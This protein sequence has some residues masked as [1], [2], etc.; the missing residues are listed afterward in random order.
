MKN[1]RFSLLTFLI[2][3][4]SVIFGQNFPYKSQGLTDRQAAEHLLSRFTFGIAP[5]DIDFAVIMGLEKWFDTQ[6]NGKIS[7][8]ELTEKLKTFPAISMNTETIINNYLLGAQLRKK[9]I[10]E[11]FLLKED[12]ES[13]KAKQ[14]EAYKKLKEKYGVQSSKELERQTVNQKVIRAIYAKNQMHEVLTDFWFNHF[15]VF[16]GKNQSAQYV[17][18]YERDVIR[19][20]VNKN[21]NE[22]LLATAKSPAMLTYLDNFLSSDEQVGE[23][24]R[25][26]QNN[27]K[28]PK[29]LNENYAREI[30]ELHTLGV[31]GG[32][33]QTD[34][35]N[36]AKILTGWTLY[37][38]RKNGEKNQIA[39]MLD[40]IGEDRLAN[41]GFVRDGDFLF[42]ANRHV[43]GPKSV[44][45]KTYNQGGYEEG[46][47]LINDLAMHPS[48]A[49]F[50]SQKIAVRF[51]SDKPNP[52]LIDK[53]ARTF[54]ETKGNISKVIRT[55]VETPEF[56]N[57][58]ARRQKT[59]S[60][61]EYAVSAVR[62]LN[63]DVMF[64]AA[65]ANQIAKM[66]QKLYY[67]QAPT[68]FPD[69]GQYWINTGSLLNRMNFGLDIAAGKIAGVRIDAN[70]VFGNK[71]PESAE[72]ALRKLGAILLP[73]RDI[74]TTIQRL[75][76][77]VADPAF[78]EKVKNA[79][80]KYEKNIMEE[81]DDYDDVLNDKRP[82]EMN[83]QS[84][85]QIVGIFIGSPEFQRR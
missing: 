60:P 2:L 14:L 63:G 45:G 33:T 4:S 56:W 6:M 46:V 65:L 78:Y 21:F 75:L 36:A 77:L 42:A 11:G 30:M 69:K 26:R 28:A 32:Y 52:D 51:V 10:D 68:G 38:L 17:L 85:S 34:V 39:E 41:R 13:D 1:K 24:G 19:P 58:E 7:D 83:P 47:A 76:P 20:H 12:V 29:G 70:K 80:K 64:P 84:L 35:V 66:G 55:M 31:D 61:F 50:I 79:N 22:L 71:E 23:F 67:Y 81:E 59:K 73:E 74:E 27:N 8:P 48:T 3:M 5:G 40:K 15:N 9:A 53:M 16:M 49:K 72:D 18:S 37:P 82:L 43:T 62:S 57:E 44:L 54:L 25:N